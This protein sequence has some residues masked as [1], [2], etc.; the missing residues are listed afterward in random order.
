MEVADMTDFTKDR[1]AGFSSLEVDSEQV[2]S[3]VLKSQIQVKIVDEADI[4]VSDYQQTRKERLQNFQEQ[5][6]LRRK[7][8]NQGKILEKMAIHHAIEQKKSLPKTKDER[9]LHLLREERKLSDKEDDLTHRIRQLLD[10]QEQ[11]SENIYNFR[12][13]YERL[14]LTYQPS[15]KFEMFNDE[16][17]RNFNRIEEELEA[18]N[19]A[20]QQE[21]RKTVEERERVYYERVRL[22][23]SPDEEG[24]HEY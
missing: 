4:V 18:K 2:E 3:G 11:I 21:R 7:L 17:Q 24:N 23:N 8:A 1:Q 14:M 22:A 9:M 19:I 15:F 13:L 20:L 10:M 5:E 16:I 6:E 12:T